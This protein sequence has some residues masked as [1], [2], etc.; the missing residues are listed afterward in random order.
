MAR[1]DCFDLHVFPSPLTTPAPVLLALTVLI[2]GERTEVQREPLMERP[3]PAVEATVRHRLPPR[4]HPGAPVAVT[5]VG[6]VVVGT[7]VVVTVVQMAEAVAE[8][9]LVSAGVGDWAL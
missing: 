1:F 6:T 7:V 5:V 2:S 3:L 4:P 8:V 9:L